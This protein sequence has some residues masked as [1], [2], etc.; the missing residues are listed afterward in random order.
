MNKSDLPYIFKPLDD[1]LIMLFKDGGSR[2]KSSSILD[3]AKPINGV[4]TGATWVNAP[5]YNHSVLYFDGSNDIINVPNNSI[6]STVREKMTVLVWVKASYES[7]I[8]GQYDTGA[9]ARSWLIGTDATSKKLRVLLSDD[10]TYN[11]NHSKDY[12]SVNDIFDNNWH[13]VGF[14][15]SLGVLKLYVDGVEQSVTKTFDAPFT[16]IKEPNCCFVIGAR[17][18][19]NIPTAYFTG[20]IGSGIMFNRG[21]NASDIMNEYNKS[22]HLYGK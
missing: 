16:A 15:W 22:K 3:L 2:T 21:L 9:L 19:N 5:G 17:I 20:Y 18:I 8:A 14:T 12:N 10:G 1:S 6:L 4:I 7:Y 11:V 13:Q